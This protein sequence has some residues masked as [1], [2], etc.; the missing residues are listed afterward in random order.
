MYEF[1]I[2]SFILMYVFL[3]IIDVELCNCWERKMSN[4]GKV[5]T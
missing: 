2:Y 4:S 5:G 3:S 1:N